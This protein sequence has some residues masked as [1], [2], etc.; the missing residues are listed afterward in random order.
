MFRNLFNPDS[1]LMITMS[2]ITD[3]I[4]L[5]LFWL[6]GCLPMITFGGVSAA[7][8][9]ST[10]RAFRRGDKH[11]WSRFWKGFRENWK[12]GIVPGLVYLAVFAAVGWV[13]IQVWNGAVYGEIS[14]MI[15]SAAAFAAV[16]VLGVLN[17]MMPMLSR[18]E[19]SLSALL[20]NTVVLALGNLPGT[21]A[22]G[23]VN[24]AAVIL[25]IRF[26]FPVFF[27]PCLAALISSLFIEPM[28]RPYMNEAS[29]D[30]AD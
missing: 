18:F 3:C 25:S 12:P 6:L 19:N 13:M 14:W 29:E 22:V 16:A 7:L 20:G 15:F 28:F 17:V 11:S 27:L 9:D 5:S 23:M 30:A 21:L 10:F 8:Y 2:W 24:A 4:F 1:N 26:V